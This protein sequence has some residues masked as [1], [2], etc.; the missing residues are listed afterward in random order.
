MTLSLAEYQS[1]LAHALLGEDVCPMDA[2]AAGFRFTATLSHAWY[3]GRTMEVGRSVLAL[4]PAIERRHLVA[5]YVNLGG[6]R[7]ISPLDELK[8]FLVFLAPRLPDPSHALSLCRMDQALTRARLGFEA[9]DEP[10]S[11]TVR[12]RTDRAVRAHLARA[13]WKCIDVRVH[14]E[15]EVQR[16]TDLMI[17]D[18]IEDAAWECLGRAA[19]SRIEAGTHASLV[20]FYAEPVTVLRAL[21][22]GPVPPVG[23][24]RYPLLFAPGL[25]NLYRAASVEE[26]VLWARLPA[27]DADPRL[28]ERLLAEGVVQYPEQRAG[29]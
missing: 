4:L 8:A 13:A 11:G 22:G 6:G 24:V 23:P 3:E 20:W 1:G 18:R 29:E 17:R 15:P 12:L 14:A 16:C 9:H 28:I 7:A 26:A 10:S 19:D 27:D 2:A 5:R 21:H 25:P